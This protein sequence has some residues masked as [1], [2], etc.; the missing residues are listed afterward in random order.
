MVTWKQKWPSPQEES[1]DIQSAKKNSR[2]DSL[3]I[4]KIFKDA[5][6]ESKANGETR[7]KIVD[8]DIYWKLL[9]F[10]NERIWN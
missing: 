8:L 1:Q 6:A 3:E 10:C 9:A 4:E 7:Q 2:K 5:P